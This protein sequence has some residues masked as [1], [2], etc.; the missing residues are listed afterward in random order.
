MS[1]GL[2]QRSAMQRRKR[3]QKPEEEVA[4]A[5]AT[6]AA[7]DWPD[8]HL[9]CHAQAAPTLDMVQ[10]RSAAEE[11]FQFECA[12]SDERGSVQTPRQQSMAFSE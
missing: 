3:C 2:P 1:G 8:E 10:H 11:G 4:R 6:S 7:R 5:S 12:S 9:N